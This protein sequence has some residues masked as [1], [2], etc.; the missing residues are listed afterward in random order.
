MTTIQKVT[1]EEF[2]QK[3]SNL[4]KNILGSNLNA[5]HVAVVSDRVP[6]KIAVVESSNFLK[7][8]QERGFKI[9]ESMEDIAVVSVVGTTQKN[10]TGKKMKR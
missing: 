5:S 4:A 3:F 2:Q 1:H 8:L 9:P 7:E 6:S 10:T